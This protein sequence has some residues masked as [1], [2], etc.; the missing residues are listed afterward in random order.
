M[1]VS[2]SRGTGRRCIRPAANIH[3]GA[4]AL[5]LFRSWTR[6]RGLLDVLA[7]RGRR[8][9][10]RFS[11]KDG[12]DMRMASL[13][14]L[15]LLIAFSGILLGQEQYGF[16][17]GGY[18]GTT[19]WKAR[20]FQVNLPQTPSPISL[21]FHYDNKTPFGIRVNLLSQR[22]WGGELDYSYQKNTATLT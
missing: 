17:F 7:N 19:N 2:G 1:H 9:G 14:I 13:L 20:T 3:R 15:L 10:G 16:E 21:G 6:W 18:A 12:A 22:H 8:S 4:P 5:V 11:F